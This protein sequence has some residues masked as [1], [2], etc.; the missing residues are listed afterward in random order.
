MTRPLLVT[1][2]VWEDS[3]ANAAGRPILDGAD[4]YGHG[5]KV[6]DEWL[7]DGATQLKARYNTFEGRLRIT[8]T[9]GLVVT[10]TG[11]VALLPDGT[12]T[13]I[14]PGS[15]NL[16]DDTSG[17]VFVSDAGVVT[18]ASSMPTTALALAQYTTLSGDVTVL[19]D[20]RQQAIE[21]VAPRSLPAQADVLLVGDTKVSARLTPEAG[22]V[23]CNGE[24]RAST[25][26]PA[27]FA[28]IGTQYNLPGDLPSTYR[29]PD[30]RGRSVVGAGQGTGLTNR[31]LG[32]VFGAEQHTLL[33]SEIPTHSHGFVSAPHSHPTNDPK[34]A[35]AIN[36]PGHGHAIVYGD[37]DRTAGS[38]P[39][40]IDGSF[41]KGGTSGIVLNA[42]TGIGIFAAATGVTVQ[43]AAISA[44]VTASG[45]GGSHNI[46]QPSIALNVF[47]RAE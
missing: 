18:V 4:A 44:S 17:F 43:P 41:N 5:D 13:S 24:S 20:L 28:A 21:I 11:A 19:A 45:G 39:D 26:Y 15:I 40:A 16:P 35:H 47:I 34:H 46:V 8:D 42:V 37:L 36:D 33:V 27:L 23:L 32:A 30:T 2:N 7:D 14:A 38:P 10:H 22:W 3:L 29:V 6:P 12:T 25:V 1:G 9:T 31:A